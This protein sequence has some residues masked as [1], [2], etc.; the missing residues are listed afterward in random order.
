MF[1]FD[2]L[3]K[4]CVM[5]MIPLGL[6]E[7]KEV[8]FREP[9]K[10]FILEHYSEDAAAYEEAISDFMDMRQV[11]SLSSLIP[12]GL[13]ETKE[14]DFREPFKDFILEHYS[15]DA[16]AYEEAISDFMD[17]RQVNSLSSLIPLGLKETKEVDFREPFKDFILEHYSGDAAAYEEAI[18]DFMDM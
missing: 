7:T 12:L 3:S 1:I 14:V 2:V 9:F 13:K 17:M 6:K 4:E 15:E 16:A 8:D 18:S 5:P 11:N 10:D